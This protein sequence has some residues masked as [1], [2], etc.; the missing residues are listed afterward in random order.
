MRKIFIFFLASTIVLANFSC[1]DPKQQHRYCKYEISIFLGQENLKICSVQGSGPACEN[2]SMTF[3][4]EGEE[5]CNINSVRIRPLNAGNC[6]IDVNLNRDSPFSFDIPVFKT[7]D[8]VCS[9]TGYFTTE[10][11]W[12]IP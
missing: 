10:N 7:D 12:I 1:D 8:F 2:T 3:S 9:P 11:E 4:Q 5:V 6:H